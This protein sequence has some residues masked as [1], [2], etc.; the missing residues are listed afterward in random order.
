M[1]FKKNSLNAFVG[2]SGCG[3]VPYLICLWDF[4]MLTGGRIEIN[5]KDIKDYSQ[6]NISNLIGSVQQEVILFDL[7]IFDNIAI[8]KINATKEEVNRRLPKKRDVMTLFQHCQ[9]DMKHE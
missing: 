9:M 1:T 4:G 2:A 5:G 7:S 6:E 3:K 8:G